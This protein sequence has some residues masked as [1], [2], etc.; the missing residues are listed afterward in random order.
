MQPHHGLV[1]VQ[2]RAHA[3]VQVSGLPAA[4]AA[5]LSYYAALPA[6]PDHYALAQP[7]SC[8]FVQAAVNAEAQ[9]HNLPSAL[10]VE[11][12]HPL[13]GAKPDRRAEAVQLELLVAQ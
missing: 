9:Q 11:V 2:V 6:G 3:G 7:E 12:R 5:E 10:A 8:I 1:A 13:A 4:S